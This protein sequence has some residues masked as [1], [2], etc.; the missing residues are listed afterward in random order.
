MCIRRLYRIVT[1]VSFAAM[2]SETDLAFK[3]GHQHNG[4]RLDGPDF[5]LGTGAP[6]SH[7]F[8]QPRTLKPPPPPSSR[9]SP[10]PPGVVLRVEHRHLVSAEREKGHAGG[11][12]Q[13][14]G[15]NG[16]LRRPRRTGRARL[17]VSAAPEMINVRCVFSSRGIGA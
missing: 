10:H 4:G 15:Q 7:Q 1:C 11:G 16:Q 17:I 14:R 3:R 2:S 8:Y 6:D 12:V 5:T 9:F 13:S